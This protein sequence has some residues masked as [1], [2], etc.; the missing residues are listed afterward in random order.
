MLL[1]RLEFS[2]GI[3]GQGST[4]ASPQQDDAVLILR[5]FRSCCLLLPVPSAMFIMSGNHARTLLAKG[6]SSGALPCV[7]GVRASQLKYVLLAHVVVRQVI[8]QEH[9]IFMACRL[10]RNRGRKFWSVHE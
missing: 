10:Q 9:D 1:A 5:R 2:A 6:N 3:V 7:R 8:L 4:C